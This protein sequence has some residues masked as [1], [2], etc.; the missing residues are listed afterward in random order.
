MYVP[1]YLHNTI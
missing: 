1:H